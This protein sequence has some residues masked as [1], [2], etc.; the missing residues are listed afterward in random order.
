[1]L[2][3]LLLAEV[4]KTNPDFKTEAQA[5]FDTVLGA[6]LQKLD[7]GGDAQMH[8]LIIETREQFVGLLGTA[9]APQEAIT[10]RRRLF[11]W[12]ASG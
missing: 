9:R 10:L 7:Q 6:M 3:S 1:V 12:L 4:L 8:E 11:N 5:A 2:A